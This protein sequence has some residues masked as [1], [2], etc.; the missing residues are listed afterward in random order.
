V[1]APSLAAKPDVAATNAPRMRMA[2]ASDVPLL[3][4][5]LEMSGRGHV[6]RGAWDV[7]FPDADERRRALAHFLEGATRSW[8]RRSLFHV[9]EM[10]GRAA[11]ALVAFAPE[12]L[13]TT[14]LAAPLFESF[15]LLGWSDARIA[16][17]GPLM[18]PYMRCFPEMPEGTWIVENVAT[19]ASARRLGLVRAL[20]DRALEAGRRRGFHDAQISCLIGNDAAQRAYER[21]GFEVVEERRDAE[22]EALIGAPGFSCMRR[23]L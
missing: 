3:V 2:D 17:V 7:L 8:C 5:V 4:S 21:A 20:L 18:A 14:S 12:D 16:S 11:A 6:E 13:P 23:R 1:S 22:F 10:D 15:A 19:I 9:A